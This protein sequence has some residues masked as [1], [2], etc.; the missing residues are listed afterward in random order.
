MPTRNK[1]TNN[2]PK[3][4]SSSSGRHHR[5]SAKHNS[6]SRKKSNGR[7]TVKSSSR[8]RAQRAGQSDMVLPGR[9]GKAQGSPVIDGEHEEVFG[10]LLSERRRMGEAVPSVPE[11]K[12][13]TTQSRE[14]KKTPRTGVAKRR[15]TL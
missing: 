14:P 3:R 5:V 9:R 7:K 8:T 4:K 1:Q 12:T 6:P 2:A 13:K 15:R 10:V 11:E